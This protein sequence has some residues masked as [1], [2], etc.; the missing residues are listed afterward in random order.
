MNKI[1]GIKKV[2]V[3]LDGESVR[4]LNDLARHS[5]RTVSAQVRFMVMQEYNRQVG[6][7]NSIAPVKITRSNQAAPKVVTTT[8]K[9]YTCPRCGK[10]CESEIDAS[11]ET[12][13]PACENLVMV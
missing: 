8:R 9:H 11:G 1:E 7:V 12:T 6:A 13:C 3:T 4:L 2:T 5:F 10:W